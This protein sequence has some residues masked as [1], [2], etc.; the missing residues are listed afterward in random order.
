MFISKPKIISIMKK[1]HTLL[2]LVTLLLFTLAIQAQQA[3]AQPYYGEGKI[4]FY[5]KTNPV[6]NSPCYT[7]DI[8]ADINTHWGT[9]S[10]IND[11]V[12]YQGKL[13]ASIDNGSGEGGV[14]VYNYADVYPS[15]TAGPV[16]VINPQNAT[17]LPVAGI[18]IQPS[19]GNLYVGTFYTGASDAGIYTYTASSGYANS[20]AAQLAS[21]NN[22]NSID[23]FIANLTFDASGNLW[24]TE[25]DGSN[26]GTGTAY[27]DHFLICYK[28]A[29][30]NNYFKIVNPS[31]TYS[32][33]SLA[34]GAGPNVYLLSQPEGIAFDASGDLWLGNNNDDYACN[35]AGDG[36]I[37]KISA[38]WITGTLFSQSYASTNTV[39]TA[40]ATVEYIPSSKP[41]ALYFDGTDIYVNDQGQNQG[42]SYTSNGVVWKWNLTTTF[43]STNFAASGIHT[44]YPG[45]GLMAFDNSQ[46]S[47]ATDCYPAG[48]TLEKNILTFSIPGQVGSSIIDT[49]SA[50]VHVLMPATADLA[51]LTPTITASVLAIISPLSGVS[52]D[53]T[54]PFIYDV[55]D[56]TGAQKAWTVTVTKQAQTG[57]GSTAQN[58]A[59]T[60]GKG[61]NMSLWL[62]SGYSFFNTTT[63]PDVTRFTKAD[64]EALHAM[65]FKTLRLP[66]FFEPFA[67]TTA[68]YTWDMTNQ[69]V[70]R[71]LDYVDS[72]IAWTGA[73]GMDLV[74]DNH[75]ADDQSSYN[76][77]ADYQITDNNYTTQA[78]LI[79]A[80]WRQAVKRYGYADP[81]RVFFELRNE[82]NSVSDANLRTLYNT[83]IDTVRKYDQ[84]HTL[85][86]GN[87]GYYDP[88]ALS[89]SMPYTDTN[90]IYTFHIYDG[91]AYP[92]FC[93]QGVGGL[94]ATDTLSNSHVSFALH[95]AQAADITSEVTAVQT[96]SATNHV[97]VWLG[98]FGTT[99]LPDVLHDDTSRCNYI[100][101]M[102]TALDAASTPWCYWDGYGPE[103]TFIS[104]DNGTTLTYTFSMFDGTNILSASHLNAC[105]ASDLGL[106]GNCT[107]G[108]S[109]ISYEKEVTIYPNPS[110]G[111]IF[112]N[113][114][115]ARV[116]DI[117]NVAGERMQQLNYNNEILEVNTSAFAA[118]VYFAR[119][120]F[121]DGTF[122]KKKF[123]KE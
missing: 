97:P 20:S 55:H 103:G 68:P 104:Y 41:G 93:F 80:V 121:E 102:I 57:T 117:Y 116:I 53:F 1:Y 24:F 11:V 23:Q 112:I 46:F 114:P 17:G 10:G 32:S 106:G 37:V 111:R 108:I 44:T 15:K 27:Q 100:K 60:L 26:Q 39:P 90:L 30:K 95:G 94:P 25:F 87:T 78:A 31:S 89:Q 12:I 59:A 13:F 64:V 8:S 73:Y 21:Y 84:T 65:C 38:S 75:L 58:R 83:V 5:N 33:T 51:A 40:S 9:T 113:A 105:F 48:A 118:G 28:A 107:T 52:E 85:V 56:V 22:D 14:L 35:S 96:W 66:V 61:M 2:L 82:P 29:N 81:S 123:V 50:T 34:G 72:M 92:G 36:T 99:T 67:A 74:I 42:S 3:I 19:T 120:G 6:A 18:A 62:E 109:N 101:N 122:T 119:I 7:L 76:L 54:S 91:D 4:R 69:N 115:G 110:T 88:I 98:E 70:V 47:L 79:A 77:Q 43:N 45:N 86:V 63:Y 16:S 71:G 49:V